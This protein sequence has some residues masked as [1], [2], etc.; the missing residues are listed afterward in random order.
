MFLFYSPPPPPQQKEKKPFI[1]AVTT[2]TVLNE[3]S[4][5]NATQRG[6]CSTFVLELPI[7]GKDDNVND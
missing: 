3:K 4:T 2:Y 5:H 1:L 6:K 7:G